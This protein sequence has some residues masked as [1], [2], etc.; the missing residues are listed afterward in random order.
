MSIDEYKRKRDFKKTPEPSSNIKGSHKR[1]FVIQEH[2]ASHLHWDLRLE[3]DGVLKSWALPKEP[4]TTPGVKRLAVQTEDH[5]LSYADFEGCFEYYTLV[6]TDQG[7]LP[8][9]EIVTRRLEVNVLSYNFRSFRLEWAPITGWFYNGKSNVF[10]KVGLPDG[11][12]E[13]QVI[14]VTPNHRVYTPAGVKSAGTLKEGDVVF[15][16][17]FNEGVKG[18]GVLRPLRV[19]FIE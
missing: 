3:L 5:P 17:T 15:T 14:Y 1:I 12:G 7:M 10:L 13:H 11:G 8:I 9:G 2:H 16:S 6:P 4:P 19:S 18:R